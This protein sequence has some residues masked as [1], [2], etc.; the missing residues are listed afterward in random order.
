MQGLPRDRHEYE[1]AIDVRRVT[2]GVP[3]DRGPA[4]AALEN[5]ATAGQQQ[6]PGRLCRVVWHLDRRAEMA[7]LVTHDAVSCWNRREP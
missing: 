5:R 6:P 3:R 2:D 4:H 1:I 7:D